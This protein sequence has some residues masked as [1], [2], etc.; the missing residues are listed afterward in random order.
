[1][2]AGRGVAAAGTTG[3]SD[4]SS[5]FATSA[6]FLSSVLSQDPFCL[7]LDFCLGGAGAVDLGA[8]VAV[9]AGTGAALAG[10]VV[11]GAGAA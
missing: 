5:A 2:G 3:L 9:L 6:L 11:A 4:S 8:G 1:M 10:A 7:I